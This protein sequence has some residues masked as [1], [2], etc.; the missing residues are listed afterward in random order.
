MPEEI[1]EC[2]TC[3]ELERHLLRYTSPT[4][5]YY[6]ILPTKNNIRIP[7]IKENL[8]SLIVDAKMIR[9]ISPQEG[10]LIKLYLDESIN[11]SR[12]PIC[13]RLMP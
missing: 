7:V 6:A 5:P 2:K 4:Y 11:G 13:L 8:S 3:A 10:C 1:E 9:L 12:Q